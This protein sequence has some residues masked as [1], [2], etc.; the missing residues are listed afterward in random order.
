MSATDQLVTWLNDAYAMERGLVP[1]LTSHAE[2]ARQEMPAAATRIEQHVQETRAHGD[3]VERCLHLLG[4]SPSTMKSTLS[5]LTGAVQGVA[6]GFFRDAPIKNALADY[7][8][9]Q[10]EVACYDALIA[11]ARELGHPEIADL[12]EQNRREDLEM[13]G[14]LRDQLP[15]TVTRAL[16]RAVR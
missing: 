12:C 2:Q 1:V 14:W 3:R 13:A 10:F 11:A 6:T 5:S 15:G 4:T 9:E 8:A 16:A 7:S